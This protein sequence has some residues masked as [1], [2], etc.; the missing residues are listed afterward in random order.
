[1]LGHFKM[2]LIKIFLQDVINDIDKV[3]SLFIQSNLAQYEGWGKGD[4]YKWRN[5]AGHVDFTVYL[6]TRQTYLAI[7]FSS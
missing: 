4:M 5:S 6:C 3:D 1:M 2:P 7:Y